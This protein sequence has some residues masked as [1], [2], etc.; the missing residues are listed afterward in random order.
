MMELK[1]ISKESI[2]RALEKA[3]RYRLLNEPFLA[4][5]ICLDILSVDDGHTGARM[6]LVLA[7][8]DR[9]AHGVTEVE[10]QA[11]IE[12]ARLPTEYERCYYAGILSERR[13]YAV[14]H[15]GI[16]S[17]EAAYYNLVRAMQLYEQAR[18]SSPEGNEDASLRFNTCVRLIRQHRLEPSP[19]PADY[20]LE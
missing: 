13:A 8:A 5:S 1:R 12:V 15:G 16:G 4:E 18:A 14:L 10:N 6:C 7:Y 19:E 2:P 9:L 3:E 20:P 11:M 17:R